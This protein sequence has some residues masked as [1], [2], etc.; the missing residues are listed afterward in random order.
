M[1]NILDWEGLSLYHMPSVEGVVVCVDNV[2]GGDGLREEGVDEVC[3]GPGFHIDSL[4]LV[5][6]TS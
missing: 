1:E 3:H 4:P 6:C 2:Q 5:A